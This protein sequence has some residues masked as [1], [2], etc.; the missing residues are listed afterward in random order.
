MKYTFLSILSC[1][2][3]SLPAFAEPQEGQPQQVEV[4][5]ETGRRALLEQQ[6]AA[7]DELSLPPAQSLGDTPALLDLPVDHTDSPGATKK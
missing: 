1:V 5:D 4:T 2:A 7:V 6:K 3:L